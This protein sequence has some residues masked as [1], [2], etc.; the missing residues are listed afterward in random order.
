[1]KY[2]KDTMNSLQ[3][4]YKSISEG[5]D[6]EGMTYKNKQKLK[7][8]QQLAKKAKEA[9]EASNKIVRKESYEKR[10]E[11]AIKMSR[12]QY[13]SEEKTVKHK[14]TQDEFNR[15]PK[16]FRGGTKEKPRATV[17]ITDKMGNTT[18]VSREVEIIKKKVVPEG[19]DKKKEMEDKMKEVEDM[20]SLPTR[21]NLIKTKLRAMGLNMSHVLKGKELSEVIDYTLDEVTRQKKEMGYV[22]GGTKKPTS[23]KTPDP[24][25]DKVTKSIYAA[26]GK[27][28]RSGSNQQKKV[29]GG[30]TPGGGKYLKMQQQKNQLKSDA[31]KR[32]FSNIQNYVDTMAIYGG[33]KNYDQGRGSGS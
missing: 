5:D 21:M 25:L 17:G 6:H 4:A 29:R 1:M 18:P 27:I 28:M 32:G 10:I 12:K 7:R 30:P 11:E 31:E 8:Q 16:D 20:R 15:I 9:E 24:A 23:P 33:K 22:V 3:E 19:V 26:G 13:T 2:D 14:M